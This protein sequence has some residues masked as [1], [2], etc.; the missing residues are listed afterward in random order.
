LSRFLILDVGVMATM[1]VSRKTAR[2]GGL[3]VMK[4]N[5]YRKSWP[6]ASDWAPA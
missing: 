1:V 2:F 4:A 6:Y 3:I 5:S